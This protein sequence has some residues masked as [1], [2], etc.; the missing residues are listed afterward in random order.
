MT[1]VK[2]EKKDLLY[3]SEDWEIL[4]DKIGLTYLVMSGIN[5][6]FSFTISIFCMQRFSNLYIIPALLMVALLGLIVYSF[7]KRKDIIRIFTM[8]FIIISFYW[9]T[10]AMGIFPQLLVSIIFS[11]TEVG[12]LVIYYFIS[13]Y[14]DRR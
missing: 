13:R 10:E 14:L 3:T 12:F 11:I 6:I 4:T 8:L 5:F 1:E 2:K 9:I 7:I